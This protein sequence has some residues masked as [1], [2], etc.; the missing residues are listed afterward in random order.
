MKYLNII[1]VVINC[2]WATPLLAQKRDKDDLK[3]EQEEKKAANKNKVD[4]TVFRRQILTLPEFD[5][6]KKKLAELKKQ[7]GGVPKIYAVVD[8]LNDADDGKMLTGYILTTLGDNSANVYEITFDRMQRKIVK[9]K[10]TGEKLEAA[11]PDVVERRDKNAKQLPKKK[12]TGDEED[13]GTED[14]DEQEE[15]PERRKQKDED[16]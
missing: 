2:F 12:K 15:K 8:S 13:E 16:E 4:Y 9:V 14:E 7:T 6:E 3:E 1:F 5:A 10:P 11:T